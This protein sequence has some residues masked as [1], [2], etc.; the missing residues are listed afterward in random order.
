M[1][2]WLK[3]GIL[4]LAVG[5]LT[6]AVTGCSGEKVMDKVLEKTDPKP[7]N[8]DK[9]SEKEDE[10][11]T[12]EPE[13]TVAKPEF[14][15]NLSGSVTY[16]TGDKAEALKVE[17]KTSDKGVITYQWYQ[18]QTNTNG[19]G[20]PV[21]GETKNTFTPPTNEAKTMF[22]YVVATSTIGSSTNGITS[23]TAEIIV[24]DDAESKDAEKKKSEEKKDEK[25]EKKEKTS[26]TW[27]ESDKGWWY[28]YGDGTYPKSQWLEIEGKWYAFD[29]HGYMR[30][31]WYQEGSA[32]YYLKDDGS[33]AVD[34][35]VEGYHLGSDGKMQ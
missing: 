2:K 5:C 10:D 34:T 18:S 8:T 25:K 35:D 17:V 33:M 21:E 29:D 15:T 7:E 1:N 4:L 9:S 22:Y 30:K 14:T 6:F 27:T 24:S 20:T 16:K 26:G 23:D 32:W 12:Q 3:K 19:G 11:K 13:V 31:G 28:D